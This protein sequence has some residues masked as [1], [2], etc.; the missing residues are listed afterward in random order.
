MREITNAQKEKVEK[1]LEHAKKFL[2]DIVKH[3]NKLDSIP[4]DAVVKFQETTKL[5]DE[6]TVI[7]RDKTGKI[8]EKRTE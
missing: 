2:L 8:I 6:L 1:N 7:L 3:P 5:K 4:N